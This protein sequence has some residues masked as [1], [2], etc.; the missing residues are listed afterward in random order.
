VRQVI[1]F[2]DLLGFSPRL[3]ALLDLRNVLNHDIG[4]LH[5]DMGDYLLVRNPRTVRGG[6][7]LVF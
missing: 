4:L 7:S 5:T 6:I 2:P 3:E 1:P